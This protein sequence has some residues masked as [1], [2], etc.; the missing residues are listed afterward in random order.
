MTT[1]PTWREGN[2]QID[3]NMDPS[4]HI[5]TADVSLYN[6]ISKVF[7]KKYS[8]SEQQ[9]TIER[10]NI[11]QLLSGSNQVTYAMN[12]L[13][14]DQ[15]ENVLKSLAPRKIEVINTSS[16]SGLLVIQALP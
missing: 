5:V 3:F 1:F 12:N 16:T 10:Y 11:S 13:K 9:I 6:S 4:T 8:V 2:I 15:K 14:S 7:A